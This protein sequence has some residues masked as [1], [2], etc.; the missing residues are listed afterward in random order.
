[1]FPGT[2]TACSVLLP[3]VE[4]IA[5]SFLEVAAGI[6]GELLWPLLISIDV[7]YGCKIRSDSDVWVVASAVLVRSTIPLLIAWDDER[8]PL[9]QFRGKF[10]FGSNA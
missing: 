3:S 2:L 5:A 9:G 1:M 7:R 4:H 10:C 8:F 6:H